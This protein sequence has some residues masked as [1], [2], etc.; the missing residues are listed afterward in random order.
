MANS[1]AEN[2]CDVTILALCYGDVPEVET[3]GR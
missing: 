1:L 3:Q 2:G